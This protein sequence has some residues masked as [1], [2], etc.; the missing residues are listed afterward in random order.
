[1]KD[2]VKSLLES[3]ASPEV[4]FTVA[5]TAALNMLR[6]VTESERMTSVYTPERVIV[7]RN[8]VDNKYVIE[9][10]NN[11][12]RL[13]LDQD[14]GINEAMNMVADINEIDISECTVVFD[15]SC[16]NRIDIS[17]VIRLDTN[18]DLARK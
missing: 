8:P 18:F 11:L 2:T 17:S 10:A 1:M 7:A 12:E 4:N 14:L 3:V 9:Y 15:D 16:I 6:P 13:M 5:N